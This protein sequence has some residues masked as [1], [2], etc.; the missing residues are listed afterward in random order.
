MR[1]GPLRVVLSRGDLPESEHRVRV[2]VWLD[3]KLETAAGDVDAPVFLRSSAKPLQ[4]LASVVTGAAERFSMTDAELAL[5]CG[6]HGGEPVHVATAAGLL[7]RIGLG[8]DHLL[9]GAHP[10][11]HD[12]AARDLV[13]AGAE[14]T[15]LHNNCS[16]KHSSMLAACVAM[17]WPVEDYVA[18]GHPLQ[19]MNVAHV[20]A[21]A[22]IDPS[23]VRLG[24]DGCSAPNFAIPLA[25]AARAFAR[26]ATPATADGVP[27]VARD[28]AER[29]A[30]ALA[31]HPEMI[32]GTRRVDTDLIRMTGGRVLAKM[33]AEGV[34]CL[35]IAGAR[36]G[37]A[38][39]AE[40]GANRAAYPVGL[41]ILRRLGALADAEWAALAPY[42]DPVLRNHRRIAVGRVEVLPPSGERA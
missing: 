14:P 27:S 32:G 41:G 15:T 34:W 18:F 10:P 28:A 42:H 13:R 26:W 29:I 31:V 38:I 36:T 3:G 21:F 1:T 39:K 40:D 30:R 6:S 11:S 35:S 4:A 9:C 19:R 5:A 22:G 33:G 17:G 8:P 24:V 12:P 7:A 25:E 16:G 2:A 20:A 23:Q 37:I